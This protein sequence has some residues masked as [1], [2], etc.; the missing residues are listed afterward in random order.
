MTEKFIIHENHEIHENH[1]P[2]GHKRRQAHGY[3][4][5]IVQNRK[6]YKKR[7]PDKSLIQYFINRSP[8]AYFKILY[9]VKK[10]VF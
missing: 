3:F 4:Q 7:T 8:G 5:D 2:S 10:H 1:N 9:K 6:K